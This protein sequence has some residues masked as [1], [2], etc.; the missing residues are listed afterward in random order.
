VCVYQV[1]CSVDF[2]FFS[3]ALLKL[4]RT[5][6]QGENRSWGN[7]HFSR[8]AG[9]GRIS[10]FGRVG[11]LH[12]PGRRRNGTMDRRP[13]LR[14]AAS[15]PARYLKRGMRSQ[16][17]RVSHFSRQAQKMSLKLALPTLEAVMWVEPIFYDSDLKE[18]RIFLNTPGSAL[19]IWR[20]CFCRDVCLAALKN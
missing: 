9:Q 14:A 19:R 8:A 4:S 20:W 2:E 10:L 7:S 17:V 16:G 18:G 11:L 13:A 1:T 3:A 5:L 6:A 12:R 15:V